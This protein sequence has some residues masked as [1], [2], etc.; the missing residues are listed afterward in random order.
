MTAT[1]IHSM[2]Y[3]EDSQLMSKIAENVWKQFSKLVDRELEKC[4]DWTRPEAMIA[5]HQT[6]DGSREG[7][8]LDDPTILEIIQ[9]GL[10]ETGINL[11][12]FNYRLS[13]HLTN[14][15]KQFGLEVDKWLLNIH[16][17]PNSEQL[18]LEFSMSS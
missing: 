2:Q 15:L 4:P 6:E 1:D 13:E 8:L 18:E 7:A 5:I 11:A 16:N 10:A 12:S 9:N 17:L 3:Y 14:Y